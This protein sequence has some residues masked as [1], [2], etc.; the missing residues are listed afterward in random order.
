[1]WKEKGKH[2]EERRTDDEENVLRLGKEMR[3]RNTTFG[4][5]RN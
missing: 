3:I 4:R 5:K 2:R 1:L